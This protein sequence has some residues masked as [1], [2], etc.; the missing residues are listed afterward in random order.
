[1]ATTENCEKTEQQYFEIQ[2][3][4]TKNNDELR[5]YSNLGPFQVVTIVQL[6]SLQSDSRESERMLERR[7]QPSGKRQDSSSFFVRIQESDRVSGE[8]C[9]S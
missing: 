8:N 1:M 4:R 2:K 3:S 5:K 9:N 7:D 6:Q